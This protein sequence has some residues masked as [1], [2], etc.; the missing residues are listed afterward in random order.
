[1][2][3][4]RHCRGYNLLQVNVPTF[5]FID[6]PGVQSLPEEDRIQT[7]PCQQLHQQR[8]KLRSRVAEVMSCTL[9]RSN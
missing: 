1:M 5:D 4:E 3:T 2:L 6:L 9:I 7:E 8:Y